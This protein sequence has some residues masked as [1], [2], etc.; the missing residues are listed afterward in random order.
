MSSPVSISARA[1]REPAPTSCSRLRRRC[2]DSP[3]QAIG[4][5]GSI[6]A[7]LAQV[8]SMLVDLE[9]TLKQVL[10][11]AAQIGR[12]IATPLWGGATLRGDHPDHRCRRAIEKG[13]RCGNSANARR[14]VRCCEEG[15]GTRAVLCEPAERGTSLDQWTH[16]PREQPRVH[17]PLPSA[18]VPLRT[19]EGVFQCSYMNAAMPGSC[20]NV[21]G[22]PYA[23]DVALLQ[24]VLTQAA[25][26]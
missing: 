21:K 6:I 15:A 20:A 3:D 5:I 14:G 11:D 23:V 8:T 7:N 4:D 17:V 1:T 13:T 16:Q 18:S 24:Y 22:T 26:R 2:L 12:E 10:E 19:P 9:P 25:N